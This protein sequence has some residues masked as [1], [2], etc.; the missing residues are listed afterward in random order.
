MA[1]FP[2][3]IYDPRTLQNRTGVT[4]D[5]AKVKVLFAEDQNKSNAEIVAIEQTLG[6]NPEGDEETVAARIAAIEGAGGVA[7]MSV[8]PNI[9]RSSIGWC[10]GGKI[11]NVNV[12]QSPGVVR[13]TPIVL[14]RAITVA[15]LSIFVNSSPTSGNFNLGIYNSVDD[16]P[17]DLL[18][19]SGPVALD[20]TGI[21]VVSVTGLTLQPGIYWLAIGLDF[22]G[23]MSL[24]CLSAFTTGICGYA[25]DVATGLPVLGLQ[26]PFTSSVF[27]DPLDPDDLVRVTAGMPNIYLS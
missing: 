14:H 13:M 20:T 5:A 1:V 6:L 7:P 3:A 25:I 21:N 23:S 27:P 17:T 19:D 8:I 4:F 18:Y 26:V 15:A 22:S 10:A 9:M 24:G 12:A 11:S 16:T 2:D